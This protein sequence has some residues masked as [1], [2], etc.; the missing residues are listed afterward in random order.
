LYKEKQRWELRF[1]KTLGKYGIIVSYKRKTS[2]S[3]SYDN[4]AGIIDF[5]AWQG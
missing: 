1:F 2:A 3:P 5:N 4:R